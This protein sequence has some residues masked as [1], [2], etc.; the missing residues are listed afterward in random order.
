MTIHHIVRFSAARLEQIM[1]TEIFNLSFLNRFTQ[2]VLSNFK[3]SANYFSR[4]KLIYADVY[5]KT[6]P[7]LSF[8]HQKE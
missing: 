6:T 4:D 2:A 5:P 1:K 3:E 8:I 7:P